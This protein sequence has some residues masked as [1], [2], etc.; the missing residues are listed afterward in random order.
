MAVCISCQQEIDNDYSSEYQR[1]RPKAATRFAE[2]NYPVT[3]FDT[4]YKYNTF[5][6]MLEDLKSGEK[7]KWLSKTDVKLT[8]YTITDKT[9]TPTEYL[10]QYE[11]YSV[12]VNYH[13]DTLGINEFDLVLL[14]DNTLISDNRNINNYTALKNYLLSLYEGYKLHLVELE[15]SCKGEEIRTYALATEKYIVYDDIIYNVRIATNKFTEHSSDRKIARRKTMR[16]GTLA[17]YVF[18]VD[19]SH[20]YITGTASVNIE[21]V[22]RGT[23]YPYSLTSQSSSASHHS[24]WPWVA[25]ADIKVTQFSQGENGI[26]N[27]CYAYGFGFSSVS[28][29]WSGNGFTISGTSEGESGGKSI[30][31]SM[32][33]VW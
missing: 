16:E 30:I 31:P 25:D 11:K 23:A 13:T 1:L 17:Y 8:N 12:I 6:E 7:A 27:F 15:W 14:R 21:L 2:N 24:A 26:C 22:V 3:P 9:V 33:T 32:L 5:Y 4:I 20:D 10:E 28:I 29:T 18:N 19:K